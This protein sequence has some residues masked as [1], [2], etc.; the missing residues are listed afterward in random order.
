M[1]YIHQPRRHQNSSLLHFNGSNPAT[2]NNTISGAADE[3]YITIFREEKKKSSAGCFVCSTSGWLRCCVVVPSDG[4]FFS[5]QGQRL[6]SSFPH[7]AVPSSSTPSF[8]PWAAFL[9]RAVAA[10]PGNIVEQ[11]DNSSRWYHSKNYQNQALKS[12]FKAYSFEIVTSKILYRIFFTKSALKTFI[13]AMKR[14]LLFSYEL[15]AS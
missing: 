7:S 2:D 11:A 13:L 6:I 3:L 1:T 9:A 4:W 10:L 8:L 14:P 12:N 5:L 15:T